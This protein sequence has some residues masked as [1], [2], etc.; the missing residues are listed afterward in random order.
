M[1]PGPGTFS[2]LASPE[3]I[4]LGTGAVSHAVKWEEMNVALQA[5]AIQ[6]ST[7]HA[8]LAAHIHPAG[9]MT[10]DPTLS[11]LAS[12]VLVELTTARGT[13]KVA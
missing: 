2:V 6:L 10:P 9:P 1:N 12:P 3:M 11:P 13:V 7:M 4:S 5:M 8:L